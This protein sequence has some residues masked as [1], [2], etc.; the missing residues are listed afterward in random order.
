MTVKPSISLTDDQYAFVRNLVES[1]RFG[2]VSAVVQESLKVFRERIE[3][4]EMEREALRRV[5]LPRL[6]GEFVTGEEMDAMILAMIAKE[7]R[8]DDL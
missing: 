7:H 2:S 1:G 4:E 5:L 6:E 3:D 8:D